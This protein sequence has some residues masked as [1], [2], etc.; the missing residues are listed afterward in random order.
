MS[1]LNAVDNSWVSASGYRVVYWDYHATLF[2][3]S[4]T[5]FKLYAG[6]PEHRHQ[7]GFLVLHF[8]V[9][10]GKMNGDNYPLVPFAIAE[11]SGRVSTHV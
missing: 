10:T 2:G 9:T 7:S 11:T 6:M 4:S 8:N 5:A 3:D 1:G